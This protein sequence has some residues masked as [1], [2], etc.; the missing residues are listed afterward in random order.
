MG[1]RVPRA[2]HYNAEKQRIVSFPV[3]IKETVIF[4]KSHDG[5]K[6]RTDNVV[7]VGKSFLALNI[8]LLCTAAYRKSLFLIF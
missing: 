8:T 6:Y 5:E 2:C 1:A 3:S 7:S 4:L